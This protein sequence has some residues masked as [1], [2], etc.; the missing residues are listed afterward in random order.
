[1]IAS[2]RRATV[3]DARRIADVL[4][5]VIAEGA[6]TLFDVPF[7]E[8]DER[9]FIASLG[10]RSAVFVAEIDGEIAGVQSVDQFLGY[11]RS[12]CH[13]ATMGTW[14]RSGVRGRGIGRLLAAE[15]F[16]FAQAHGYSKIVIHVL[17]DNE[18]ALRF[19]R[20]LGFR[21]IGIARQHV[22]LGDHFHDEIYLEK[23]L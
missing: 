15:S 7:S 23:I 6:Y 12:T 19:Y 14:L 2:V 11:A 13:V 16:R 10:D 3:E 8:E 20:R 18:R 1:M 21:D 17:A 9:T 22:R 4:N 5:A